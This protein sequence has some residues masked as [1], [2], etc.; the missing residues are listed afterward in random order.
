MFNLFRSGAKFTKYMLGGLLLIVAASMVTYLIPNTG[1]TTASGNGTDN[2]L[3]EIGNYT[4][5][6]D[7]AKLALDRLINGGQL[8]REA[9]DVYLRNWWIR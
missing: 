6:S 9:A 2:V 4:V 1:L 7:E 5:T 3:A 8:P